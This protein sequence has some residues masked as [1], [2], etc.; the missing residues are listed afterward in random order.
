MPFVYINCYFSSHG[1]DTCWAYAQLSMVE[2]NEYPNT[3]VQR[4]SAW[5]FTTL[6]FSYS[7][8]FLNATVIY[9]L[10]KVIMDPFQ[11]SDKR[12][13]KNTIKSF[14]AG[15][16]FCIVGLRLTVS[17]Y[18]RAAEWNFRIYQLVCLTNCAGA[19]YVI[20]WLVIRFKKPGMSGDIKREIRARYV[21]YV[22]L[23]AIFSWPV[24]LV[25]RPSFRYIG[26]LNSYIGST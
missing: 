15:L 7:S 13:I 5:Y 6:F 11:S 3:V 2:L 8:L 24:C 14:C 26:T 4:L 20:I 10:K 16:V 1:F 21:E 9:D 17:T 23:Y 22:V 25:T 18:P 12:I 19:T